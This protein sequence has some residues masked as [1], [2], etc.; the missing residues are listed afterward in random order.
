M[1]CFFYR[2]KPRKT[3]AHRV[4]GTAFPLIFMARVA[5]Q[6]DSWGLQGGTALHR[7]AA[8][9]QIDLVRVMLD[10]GANIEAK[11][12]GECFSAGENP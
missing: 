2:K 9:G 12:E 8:K 4:F 6:M 7:A 3:V 5:I 1:P 11:D 10:R